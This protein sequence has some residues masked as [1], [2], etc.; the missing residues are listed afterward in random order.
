M[1]SFC[2]LRV[3]EHKNSRA[4]KKMALKLDFSIPFRPRT[5]ASAHAWLSLSAGEKTTVGVLITEETL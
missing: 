2:S 1:R 4:H 5:V 3:D